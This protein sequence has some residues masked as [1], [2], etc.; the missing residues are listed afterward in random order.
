MRLYRLRSGGRW[1]ERAR[2]AGPSSHHRGRNRTCL[3]RAPCG[4]EM[5]S[6]RPYR[7]HHARSAWPPPPGWSHR[8]Q[9]SPPRRLARRPTPR[10]EAP[11]HRPTDLGRA[12]ARCGPTLQVSGCGQRR[13]GPGLTRPLTDRREPACREAGHRRRS[14]PPPTEADDA[15]TPAGR[16][17]RCMQAQRRAHVRPTADEIGEPSGSPG[18][19]T[20]TRHGDGRARSLACDGRRVST[21]G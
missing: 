7:S 13:L 5:A 18:A 9:P 15:R 17:V 16:G 4:L 10:P 20:G 1:D 11:A 19:G 14:G 12:V 8:K 2:R 21:S 6:L 3:M